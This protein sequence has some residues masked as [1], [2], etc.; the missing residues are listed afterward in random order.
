MVFLGVLEL[1]FCPIA[2]YS[3]SIR[4]MIAKKSRMLFPFGICVMFLRILFDKFGWKALRRE[5]LMGEWLFSSYQA[6]RMQ[7]EV[8]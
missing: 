4:K 5:I 8:L 2:L 7:I 3:P 6:C 1:A